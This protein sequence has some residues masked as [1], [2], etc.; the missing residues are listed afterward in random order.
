MQAKQHKFTSLDIANA[1]NVS[2]EKV[3]RDIRGGKFVPGNLRSLSIYVTNH[4][5]EEK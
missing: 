3:R 5:L 2:K 1:A 4:I